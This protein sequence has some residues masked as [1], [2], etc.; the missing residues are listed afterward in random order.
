MRRMQQGHANAFTGLRS[1][2]MPVV[3]ARV[4]RLHGGDH[5][6]SVHAR[7]NPKRDAALRAMQ[8]RHADAYPHVREHV[9]LG[10]VGS[11]W[12]LRR[13]YGRMLTERLEVLRPGHVGMVLRQQVRMDRRLRFVW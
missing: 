8:H 11:F 5:H 9:H 12:H 13:S 2:R 3:L 10:R 7:S 1:G 4:E 6:P